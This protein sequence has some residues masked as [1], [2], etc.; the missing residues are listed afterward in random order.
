MNLLL[1]T[2]YSASGK[3]TI[4]EYINRDFGYELIGERTILHNLAVRNGYNRTREWVIGEDWVT[5]LHLAR[6]ATIEMIAS[7]STEGVILDGSYDRDLPASLLYSLPNAKLTIIHIDLDQETRD[8]RMM[9]RMGESLD[10]AKRER[11]LIDNFKK[12]AGIE[13]IISKADIKVANDGPE[14]ESIVSLKNRLNA[15]EI[16]PSHPV[17][18]SN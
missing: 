8:L 4:A 17:E 16:K 1:F 9:A 5:I 2:G 12:R 10:I 11:E 18:H 14:A 13:Y 3:S 7:Q 6:E 15:L